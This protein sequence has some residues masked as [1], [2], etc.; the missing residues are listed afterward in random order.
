MAIRTEDHLEA[1]FGKAD[2][3]HL[4]WQT[5]APFVGARERE[6]S[7][8]E[9]FASERLVASARAH[10]LVRRNPYTALPLHYGL[11]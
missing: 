7:T 8:L 4:W 3:E 10:V 2:A 5:E 1:A 6:L 11:P 9:L